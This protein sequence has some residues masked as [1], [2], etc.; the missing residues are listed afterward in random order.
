M[1][2]RILIVRIHVLGYSS[3]RV[4]YRSVEEGSRAEEILVRAEEE[5]PNTVTLD[6][7]VRGKGPNLAHGLPSQTV[8]SP[9]VIYKM[10]LTALLSS[11]EESRPLHGKVLLTG[12]TLTLYKED[13]D[14]E[15]RHS[16]LACPSPPVVSRQ[17]SKIN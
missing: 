13:Q 12:G 9:D 7:Q 15:R 4:K 14:R 8:L 1:T 10:N 2:V 5:D 16:V 11:Q 17:V 3:Y 6:L